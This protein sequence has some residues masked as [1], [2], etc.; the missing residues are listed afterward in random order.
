MYR[1][2]YIGTYSIFLITYV[3]LDNK[4]LSEIRIEKSNLI[5]VEL[6]VLNLIIFKLKYTLF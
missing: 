1:I 6:T 3:N 4:N 5:I 2:L